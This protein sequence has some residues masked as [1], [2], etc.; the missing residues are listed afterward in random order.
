LRASRVERVRQGNP[1]ERDVDCFASRSQRR[2]VT[3]FASHGAERND[4]AIQA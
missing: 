1:G 2:I 4:V 3:V